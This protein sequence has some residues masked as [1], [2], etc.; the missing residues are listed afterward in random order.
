MH[1]LKT[2]HEDHRLCWTGF[3]SQQCKVFCVFNTATPICRILVT[4][5]VIE[6]HCNIGTSMTTLSQAVKPIQ[7]HTIIAQLS[8]NTLLCATAMAMSVFLHLCNSICFQHDILWCISY[9]SHG[10]LTRWH[11]STLWTGTLMEGALTWRPSL[12]SLRRWPRYRGGPALTLLWST[13]GEVTLLTFPLQHKIYTYIYY[14]FYPHSQN[15]SI[16]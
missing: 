13:A 9:Y 14:I 5:P 16:S 10:R 2:Q 4:Q 15:Y 3:W 11:S 7:L 1:Q 8:D 6:H 12:V